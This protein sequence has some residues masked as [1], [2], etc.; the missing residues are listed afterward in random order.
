M[1]SYLDM[2]ALPTKHNVMKFFLFL[3]EGPILDPKLWQYYTH[4]G[5][6]IIRL[7]ILVL[8]HFIRY[9][10]RFLLWWCSKPFYFFPRRG[11][12]SWRYFRTLA[13]DFSCILWTRGS[14]GRN[15]SPTRLI[16]GEWSMVSHSISELISFIVWI[17]GREVTHGQIDPRKPKREGENVFP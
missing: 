16:E 17:S 10:R 9:Y 3:H 15:S 13:M 2:C 4:F 7:M 5:Y 1:I 14:D 6:H 8:W 12:Y 11:G